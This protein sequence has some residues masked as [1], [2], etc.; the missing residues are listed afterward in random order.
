MSQFP[1]WIDIKEI[2]IRSPMNSYVRV[3]EKP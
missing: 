3:A 2:Y 1:A